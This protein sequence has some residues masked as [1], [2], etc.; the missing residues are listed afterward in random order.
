MIIYNELAVSLEAEID[1]RGFVK[2]NAKGETNIE[3][4]YAI[5][6][7][8]ADTKKQIYTSWDMAVDALDDIDNKIRRKL[9][10]QTLANFG[11]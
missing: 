7:L 8:Q 1:E 5:G 6:D 4:L 2:T 10:E 9:R 3:G 11:G